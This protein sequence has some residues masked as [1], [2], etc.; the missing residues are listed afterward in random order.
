MGT[1][2]P[3]AE[4]VKCLHSKPRKQ[5]KQIRSPCTLPAPALPVPELGRW[6]E[7]GRAWRRL[8]I[9]ENLGEAEGAE[10]SARIGA[11]RGLRERGADLHRGLGFFSRQRPPSPLDSEC[12]HENSGTTVVYPPRFKNQETEGRGRSGKPAFRKPRSGCGCAKGAVRGPGPAGGRPAGEL[13]Q[14]A[15]F[16]AKRFQALRCRNKTLLQVPSQESVW[17][18]VAWPKSSSKQAPWWEDMY[19]SLPRLPGTCL[20]EY[21]PRTKVMAHS[22]PNLVSR[23][24]LQAFPSL[25]SKE[26]LISLGDQPQMK[27]QSASH[28]KTPK[29]EPRLPTK[30]RSQPSHKGSSASQSLQQLV[31]MA[32]WPSIIINPPAKSLPLKG[33]HL[34]SATEVSHSPAAIPL[35]YIFPK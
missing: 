33:R 25:P 1:A 7:R 3:W 10:S 21:S 30:T 18:L 35:P 5:A 12:Q 16:R 34:P 26:D 23:S 22:G 17:E 14:G 19:F 2:L 8:V 20:C 29:V 13:A 15:P 24:T 4:E 31:P 9:L 28:K 6:E 27:P 32:V 11:Q